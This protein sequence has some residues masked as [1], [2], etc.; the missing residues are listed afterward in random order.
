ML[1]NLSEQRSFHPSAFDNSPRNRSVI[2]IVL[3]P[4]LHFGRQR[5]SDDALNASR[6]HERHRYI[7][8]SALQPNFRQGKTS[9]QITH[10]LIVSE[11]FSQIYVPE[12]AAM[13]SCKHNRALAVLLDVFRH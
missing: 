5:D 13:K 10:D 8:E 6:I 7:Y 12:C 3:S 2:G 4:W 9:V 1:L 11:L